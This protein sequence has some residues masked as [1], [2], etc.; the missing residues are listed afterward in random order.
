MQPAQYLCPI[1]QSP[2]TLNDRSYRCQQN[3]SFDQA[4]EG[5]VNLLPVQQKKSKAPGDNKE[6]V[7]ARRAFLDKGYYQHLV[8]KLNH[9]FAQYTPED[10][11]L[12]DA[13]CGEGFY[14]NQ[15][16][17]QQQRVYGID[18]SKEAVKRAAKRYRDCHFS[19]ATLS[20]LPFADNFFDGLLSV[21][22]P[23]LEQEFTRVLKDGGVLITVTP[24]KDHL[25]ELKSM[26]YQDAKQ[27]D[28]E[29]E[30][31]EH[32]SLVEQIELKTEMTIAT[33]QDVL[34]L[35]QMTPYAF[36]ASEEVKQQLGEMQAFSCHAHFLIKVY[37]KTA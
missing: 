36:K 31:I 23:I 20:H 16:Q 7:I 35:Q 27:H 29:R 37:R 13:G 3:H 25:I 26:I 4:K 1:C 11:N 28:E 22:A 8:D 34:N 18:I 10:A 21:Y 15:L 9:L 12:F 14:T 6:M 2:L 19:V 17:T 33:G 30:P 5:Y 32:L 24:A